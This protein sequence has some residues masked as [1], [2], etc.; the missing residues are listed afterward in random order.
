MNVYADHA[1][2]TPLD[3]RV[4]EAMLP[5][6][7]ERFYNPSS[8]YAGGFTVR[9]AIEEARALIAA[10]FGCAAGELYF[11]SGGTESVNLAVLGAVRAAGRKGR[12]VIGATE[13]HAVSETARALEKEGFSVAVV[14]CNAQGLITPEALEQSMDD[15][16]VLVSVMWANNE[17]GIIQPVAQ[18]CNITRRHGA[19][20]HTD[21]VQAL[22]SRRIRLDEIPVDLLSCS[23]HKIYGP[24]GCGLLFVRGNTQIAPIFHGGQQEKRLRGGTENPAAII[25]FG[26][27]VELLEA[28]REDRRTLQKTIARHFLKRILD[29]PG[30]LYNSPQDSV[31]PGFVSLSI[32]G[33]ESEPLLF[34]LGMQGVDASMGAACHSQ[35][36]EP[37]FVLRAM[38]VPESHIRGSVRFSYGKD[39]TLD[40]ADHAAKALISVVGKLRKHIYENG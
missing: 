33:V 24:K 4:L 7:R 8:L 13:H 23:S 40:E 10:Y 18:L 25:G 6:L 39:S 29:I 32:A 20:F 34:H 27:A 12:I 2:T 19:L 22:G 17:T 26:K 11:T 21:A 28:E 9:R 16:V 15:R 5:F 38:G 3:A 31:I 30:I 36:I 14:L 1:A 37:S 35:V